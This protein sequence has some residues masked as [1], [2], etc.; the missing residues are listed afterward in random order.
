M[1]S[2]RSGGSK[3]CESAGLKGGSRIDRLLNQEGRICEYADGIKFLL[4]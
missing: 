3:I 4:V 1:R 2:H